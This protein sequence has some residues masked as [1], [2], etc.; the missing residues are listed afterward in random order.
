MS[1]LAGILIVAGL[2]ALFAF[3]D[4]MFCDGIR[5]KELMD[6]MGGENPDDPK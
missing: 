1:W 4:L 2:I 5:C 6:R 3:W